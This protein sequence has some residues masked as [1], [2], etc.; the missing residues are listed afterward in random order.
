[1]K[2]PVRPP[3]MRA[4]NAH[5]FEDEHLQKLTA[6][7]KRGL[8]LKALERS[9]AALRRSEYDKAQKL[10]AVS[11]GLHETKASTAVTLCIEVA[12]FASS[13]S[14]HEEA[15]Q[16]AE[17]ALSKEKGPDDDQVVDDQVLDF[18]DEEPVTQTQQQEVKHHIPKRASTEGNTDRAQD[19]SD[20]MRDRDVEKPNSKP[21][22][23]SSP[24]ATSH[25]G[26]SEPALK[27]GFFGA[28]SG[29]A[30][31]APGGGSATAGGVREDVRAQGHTATNQKANGVPGG[32]A[33]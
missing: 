19:A 4:V 9:V 23:D 20:G 28:P 3:V 18:Y 16:A 10:A 27:R 5:K 21:S 11:V 29:G 7:G 22:T 17:L 32:T 1:M 13:P 30:A 24:P 2:E 14:A 26:T 8:A 12:R 33:K 6:G 25:K 31:G 15:A